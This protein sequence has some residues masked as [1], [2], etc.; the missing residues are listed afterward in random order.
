MVRGSVYP[1]R[2]ASRKENLRVPTHSAVTLEHISGAAAP[3]KSLQRVSEHELP[4]I[5]GGTE[6]K[7]QTHDEKRGIFSPFHSQP[8]YSSRQ[9]ARVSGRTLEHTPE[10]NFNATFGGRSP[11]HRNGDRRCASSGGPCSKH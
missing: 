10:L 5:D 7:R 6:E 3:G 4:Q 1:C 11:A 2:V 9:V 8:K